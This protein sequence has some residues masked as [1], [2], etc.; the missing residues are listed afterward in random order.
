MIADDQLE[1]L[2]DAARQASRSAYCPYSHFPVGA[3]LL[4]GTGAVFG[5]C[6]VENASYGLTVCAERNA[7]FH[8]VAMGETRVQAIVIYTPTGLPTAPCGACRQVLNEF[9]PD[10][11]VISVCDG[12]ETLRSTVRELLPAAFGRQN[13]A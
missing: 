8:A 13:L 1:R 4:G 3:A 7:L 2:I 5:G 12:P 9:G 6:N 11:L 10:A